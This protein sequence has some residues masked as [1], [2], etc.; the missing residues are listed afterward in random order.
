MSLNDVAVAMSITSFS[1]DKLIKGEVTYAISSRLGAN[2]SELQ[3]FID[4]TAKTGIGNAFGISVS[5]AQE[6]RNVIGKEGA[7]GLLI[8]MAIKATSHAK[9]ESKASL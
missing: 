7:I 1:L 3:A 5:A 6:I 4:G 9:S 8:G 2:S